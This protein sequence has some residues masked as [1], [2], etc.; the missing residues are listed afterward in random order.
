MTITKN[1]ISYR[2]NKILSHPLLSKLTKSLCAGLL[3]FL[4]FSGLSLS[5]ASAQN[6]VLKR[7]EI[8]KPLILAIYGS[9]Y[10]PAVAT[11]AIYTDVQLGD[12]N[13]NWIEKLK[14]DGITEGC[15][16]DL[17]CPDM[18][19][20]KEQLAKILLKA[21][22]G[23]TYQPPIVSSS[24]FNDVSSGS[25]AVNWIKALVDEGIADGCDT[26][27]F[28]PNETV[29]VE[30][31][32]K[33]LSKAFLLFNPT[34]IP[35]TY[36]SLRSDDT[37]HHEF[38]FNA[39]NTGTVDFGFGGPESFSWSV[40]TQGRLLV[41]LGEGGL[42]D[43]YTLTSGTIKSGVFSAEVDD[44]SDG[45]YESFPTVVI[46]AVSSTGF[47]LVWSEEFDGNSL[48]AS[49]WNIETGY[50]PNNSGWG[51]DESQLYTDSS[52]NLKI[53]DGVA[54]ITARCDSGN[55]IKRNGSI[56]SAKINTKGKFEF[57]YGKVEARIKLP[58]GRSTWPAFWM[59]GA[60]YPDVSWPQSGEID[61]MEMF[62]ENSSDI[63]T[64][65]T[66]I[67]WF[68]E[69]KAAGTEWTFF[70][71]SKRFDEPLTSDFHVFTVEWD[72]DN[73]VGKID[74]E[75]FY[76]KAINSTEM[77]EFHET[78]YLILNIAIDGTLGGAPDAIKTTP[79][80]MIVD[81][82]RVYECPNTD[83][84]STIPPVVSTFDDGL[85]TSGDFE[86]GVGAWIGNAANVTE[87]L[88]GVDGTKANFADVA[89]AGNPWDVN[90]SQ[91]VSITQ[92]TSYTLT[93]KAKSNGNRTMLAGI[94][95]NQDPWTSNT[96]SVS[97]T[98][99]WQTFTL[100]LPA[101]NFG[102]ENSRVL[103]DMGADTGQVIIDE[104]SLVE[105]P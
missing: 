5:N 72:K 46:G 70:S 30:G 59:L 97:L 54:V 102:G 24:L 94:G 22:H 88:L 99:E 67:H 7:S 86:N 105:T 2:V 28:C 62:Q 44:D 50:G 82:V 4:V 60:G 75:A 3:S 89:V 33:M 13:A 11:G 66:T 93:F 49:K 73:I 42:P 80:E 52:D 55:C 79:Q 96:E 78:F 53:V 48:D 57:K 64:T 104:V 37:I 21:K 100:A 90:L 63:N 51:N 10:V 35:G 41:D 1:M 76:T 17:Y 12:F 81:W 38:I 39:D 9:D 65:H 92:G 68:D 20:T 34:N 43:R 6:E 32:E 25:F 101:T 77:S 8:S 95:L 47:N 84:V 85:L 19:V 87:E 27:N 23:S 58:S 40:D 36:D 103:F 14:A 91:V 61:I 26:N 16:T 56:T 45:V 18:A 83:C 71:Q 29:T 74:G 69:S 31:F 15:S 98:S